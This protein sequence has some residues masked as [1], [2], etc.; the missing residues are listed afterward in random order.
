MQAV[1]PAPDGGYPGGNTA[2]GQNALLSLTTGA[3]N[4]AVGWFSLGSNTTGPFNTAI[5]AGALFAN[6]TAESNTATGTGALFSHTTGNGNT[7]TGTFALFSDT[8]GQINTATGAGALFKNTTGSFSTA[9][10]SGALSSNTTGSDNTAVGTTALAN[11]TTGSENVALG[12]S[13]GANLT[14]GN[15]NIDIG[16]FVT[17]NPGEAN[18]IRIGNQGTQTATFMAGIS[19]AT[20][21]GGVSVIIDANGH[22]GTIVSSQRFKDE[23]KP[24]DD[25]SEAILALRPVTFRYKKELDPAGVPQF[26]LVAEE[27]E[28]VNPDL[29]ARDAK[30]GVFTVRYE[31]VSAMLLN[32]FLKEHRAFVEEQRKV[33]GQQKEI[34]ALKAELKEQRAMIQ[35]VTDKVELKSS[36]SQM[37]SNW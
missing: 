2:E 29:V 18:A 24:M 4:T 28:K 23:I 7:A 15:N 36:T 22:L 1:V 37:V 35:K 32:E 16:N 26:G 27:V 5:G 20:V 17:G 21:A 31:A 8:S 14:T 10:G 33:A 6:A 13:A 25:A 9:T 30:G 3:Y 19:G 11:N 34:D 12:V